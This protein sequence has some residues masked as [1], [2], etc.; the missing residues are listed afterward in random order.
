MLYEPS[1]HPGN[2]A[3][4]AKMTREARRRYSIPKPA[5]SKR[6]LG[7]RCTITADATTRPVASSEDGISPIGL[8]NRARREITLAF[9]LGSA[10]TSVLILMRPS[11]RKP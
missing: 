2:A 1:D 4:Q 11:R 8:G 7:T 6:G 5:I 3:D 9:I 10:L